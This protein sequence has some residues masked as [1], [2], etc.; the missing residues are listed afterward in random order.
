MEFIPTKTITSALSDWLGM[1]PEDD[2]N[3]MNNMG[4]MLIVGIGI[5]I[6]VVALGVVSC[7]VQTNYRAYKTYREIRGSIF[8]NAF[9][10]YII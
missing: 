3:I 1:D 10:R 2:S 5:V 4:L 6:V 7:L 8:Y 9:L